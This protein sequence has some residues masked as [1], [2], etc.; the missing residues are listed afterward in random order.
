[1]NRL[2]LLTGLLL[3]A[4]GS[5]CLT[6][7][8][9]VG[10][11]AV[12]FALAD[13]LS[14]SAIG[15]V[16]TVEVRVIDSDGNRVN[17][18]G[19]T[20]RSLDGSVARVINGNMVQSTG[21]GF[22]VLVATRGDRADSLSI[23]VSQATDTLLVLPAGPGPV[24]MVAS[25]GLLS[26]SCRVF[27]ANGQ[28]IVLPVLVASAT[29]LVGGTGCSQLVAHSSGFDTLTVTA[30]GYVTRL[31]LAIA[32]R[33][34]LASN[35][36]DPFPV[37]SLPVGLKPWAPTLYRAPSGELELYF[38]GY[39]TAPE[40]A[41]GSL[42]DLHRL[43]SFDGLA[44]RYDGIAL[45]RATALCH[46]QGT[47]IEN[48]A[49][50]PRQESPGWRMFYAAGGY[51]CYGWQVFSAVSPDGHVWSKEAGVRV[52]NGGAL[53]PAPPYDPPWPAG[54]GL[55]IDRLPSG[56]SR[57]LVGGYEH[58][59]PRENRF[60]IIEWTSQNQ[61]DWTYVGPVLTTRQ[62]GP[63]ANRSI[64]SPSV[65]ILAPGLYRMFFTG[66]NLKD[67]GGRSRIYTAVSLDYREWQVEGVL[68]GDARTDYYYSTVDR[69]LLVFIRDPLAQPRMLG[70]VRVQMP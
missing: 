6:D 50:V 8:S 14:F 11:R 9:A 63:G 21:N 55:V 22:T 18:G 17:P 39:R 66:D 44:F 27:D 47:G 3:G 10:I 40:A 56:E 62:V 31:P 41:K 30:G 68:V 35:P 1:M 28:L 4:A 23:T 42:G 59:S 29:G 36:N 26:I 60:Q 49:I 70:S 24:A 37:D 7:S 33:P 13:S 69:D 58:A 43:A 16:V 2:H 25:D 57:M 64:Y 45:R 5:G 46:P 61:L 53:P 15:D 12:E 52:S 67:P 34:T 48:L 54:E 32:I 19:F 65:V 38:A 51:D 20:L